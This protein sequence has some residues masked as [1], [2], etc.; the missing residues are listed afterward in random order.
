M[1][2]RKRLLLFVLLLLLLFQLPFVLSLYRTA[3]LHRYL[4]SL[5][6]VDIPKPPFQDIRGGIHI[7]SAAGGHSLGT[8]PEIIEAA[9]KCGYRY[10]F[11]TEHPKPHSLFQQVIDP[12]IVTIYGWDERQGGAGEML[13]T[14]DR[15]I[16]FQ[17]GD[18]RPVAAHAKGLEIFNL[19]QSAI[20]KDSWFNRVSFFYHRLLHP[21]LYFFKLWAVDPSYLRTWDQELRNRHLTGIGGSDAHQNIGL[22]LQTTAGKRLWALMADPYP[23]SLTAVTTHVIL[24]YGEAVTSDSILASLVAGSA[25]VA[26]E[27]IADPN[28]FSFHAIEEGQPRPMGSTVRP[29][30][31]LVAQAPRRAV[32]HLIHNGKVRQMETGTRLVAKAMEPGF[33]RVEVHLPDPPGDLEGKPWI[34]SNPVYVK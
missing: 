7:H 26:F 21:E 10:L 33:Y 4:A 2:R 3:R 16:C 27:K 15:A 11:I 9:K 29:G 20:L 31:G 13:C 14:G 17:S 23:E 1:T 25:Y 19:H 34:I 8:Y 32:F 24:R 6:L 18:D 30:A 28:G 12:D 22:V 5:P